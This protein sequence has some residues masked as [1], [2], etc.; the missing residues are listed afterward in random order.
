MKFL[1]RVL[2][3]IALFLGATPVLLAQQTKAKK[4]AVLADIVRKVVASDNYFF[5]PNYANSSGGS[6]EVIPASYSLKI[7][8]DS[9]AAYLPYYGNAQTS[10]NDPG[11]GSIHFIWTNFS[12]VVNTDKKGNYDIQIF[13]TKTNLGKM[14]DVK[15][16]AL[17]ISLDG[18][19]S[20]TVISSNRYAIS[21]DGSIGNQY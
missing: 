6:F 8:K 9:V 19:A 13:P 2:I 21:F 18:S 17:N 1:N 5:S 15:S 14:K 12:Y 16:L 4:K 3:A 10:G 11:D 20:L 7:S